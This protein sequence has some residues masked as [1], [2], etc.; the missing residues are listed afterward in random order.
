M[1]QIT[2][3]ENG[4]E[5][6]LLT[7][8]ENFLMTAAFVVSGALSLLVGNSA[9]LL[10]FVVFGFYLFPKIQPR[11][12]QVGASGIKTDVGT[13]WAGALLTPGIVGA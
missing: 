11:I 2:H 6:L 5:F 4:Q 8:T 9:M 13:L 10:V 1:F 7:R 3:K 12:K